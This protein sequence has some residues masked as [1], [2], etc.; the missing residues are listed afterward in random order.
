V[1]GIDSMLTSISYC[2]SMTGGIVL[3]IR[4]DICTALLMAALRRRNQRRRRRRR[5]WLILSIVIYPVMASNRYADSWRGVV[6]GGVM[7]LAINHY[8]DD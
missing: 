7:L 6:S 8:R 3:S 1:A 5:V 4:S 2:Y